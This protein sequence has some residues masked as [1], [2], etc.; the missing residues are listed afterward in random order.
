[1]LFVTL[2]GRLSGDIELYGSMH[3]KYDSTSRRQDTISHAT[4]YMKVV[5]LTK[6]LKDNNLEP[7][8]VLLAPNGAT[9]PCDFHLY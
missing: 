4:N 8:R 7:G 6:R 1:M 2:N 9:A 3:P 5:D